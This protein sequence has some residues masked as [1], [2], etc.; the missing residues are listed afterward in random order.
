MKT[1]TDSDVAGVKD[2]I[3]K[4]LKLPEMLIAWYRDDGWTFPIRVHWRDARDYFFGLTHL[5]ARE[6]EQISFSPYPFSP[7]SCIRDV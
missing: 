6:Q 7:H 3:L 4:E 1:S 5:R 2:M